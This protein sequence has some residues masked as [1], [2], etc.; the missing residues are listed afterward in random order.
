MKLIHGGDWAG[1]KAE[2]GT[3][4][5]DFSAN[6]SPLGLPDGV[7]RAVMEALEH[8]DRYPDPLCRALREKLSEISSV[9]VEHIVCGNGADDLIFRI[10]AALRPS[11]ALVTVPSF[12]EYRR[13]LEA[14]GCR[15]LE[16]RL[17]PSE[18]FVLTDRILSRIRPGLDLLFLGN[19]DNPCGRL[20]DPALLDRILLRCLESGTT[21]VA[22]ECFLDFV[23]DP[24]RHS[25]VP[26]LGENPKLLLLR[27][28]TKSHAMAGLRLGYVLCGEKTVAETLQ[29]CGQAWPVSAPAQAAGIAALEDSAYLPRLRRLISSERPRMQAALTALGF[30]VIPGE[31][32]F[33]LFHCTD[34]SLSGKLR[35]RGFLL[36]DCSGF[37][38]LGKGWYRTAVRTRPENDLLIQ[39]MEEVL[40]DG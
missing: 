26:R 11:R 30:Q 29:G 31:A 37:S 2:Y 8:A 33:L 15:V 20:P 19:P 21:V 25:L 32:D 16:E 39:A 24:S 3:L 13:A 40:A 38:G 14:V 4:P 1:Y 27:A 36:R 17:D 5:L 10:C 12:A 18:G 23:E 22:D 7:R 28:F 6:I 34:L 9:P 35:L